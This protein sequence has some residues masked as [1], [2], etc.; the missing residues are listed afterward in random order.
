MTYLFKHRYNFT[1]T[2]FFKLLW[3]I[4]PV[5]RNKSHDCCI[6]TSIFIGFESRGVHSSFEVNNNKHRIIRCFHSLV[7]NLIS[8]LLLLLLL[9]YYY[10]YCC[11]CYYYSQIR[12]VAMKFPEWFNCKHTCILTAYWEGSP[13][14]YS[15]WAAMRLVQRC[16]HCWKHFCS[17]YCRKALSDVTSLCLQYHEISVLLRQTSFLETDRSLSEQSQANRVGV[18]F[19]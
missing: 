7:M 16:C 17:I 18:P 11:C 4:F 1:F 10:C 14:N 6:N 12:D 5:H 15:P 9:Y 19:K 8:L 3:F 13:S 2:F